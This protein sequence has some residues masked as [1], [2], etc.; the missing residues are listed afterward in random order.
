MIFSH[1]C[2]LLILVGVRAEILHQGPYIQYPSPR[3]ILIIS[4]D[5]IGFY[6]QNLEISIALELLSYKWYKKISSPQ[7][8][9]CSESTVLQYSFSKKKQYCSIRINHARSLQTNLSRHQGRYQMSSRPQGTCFYH[10]SCFFSLNG[11]PLSQ[12]SSIM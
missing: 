12:H 5:I 1:F 7:I 6:C 3:I 9:K 10:D 11:C 8:P 4:C 2:P